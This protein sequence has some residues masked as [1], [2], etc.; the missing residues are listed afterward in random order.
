M[1]KLDTS[2][3]LFATPPYQ[4]LKIAQEKCKKKVLGTIDP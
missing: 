2:N 1:K 3:P 4:A